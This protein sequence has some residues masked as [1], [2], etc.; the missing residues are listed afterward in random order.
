[1]FRTTLVL[2]ALLAAGLPVIASAAPTTG[3]HCRGA[4]GRFVKCASAG[5]AMSSTPMTTASPTPKR[6]HHKKS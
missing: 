3:K 6:S 5:A 1:M 4:N 2:A